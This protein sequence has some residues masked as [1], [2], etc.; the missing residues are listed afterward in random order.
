MALDDHVVEAPPDYNMAKSSA[1]PSSAPT[2]PTPMPMENFAPRPLPVCVVEQHDD[3]L[4][5]LHHC[6]RRKILPQGSKSHF[7]HF[8]AHPDLGASQK[9]PGNL[10]NEDVREVYS[11]LKGD[12]GGIASWV[13]P[14]VLT[15]ELGLVTWV[16]QA[17]ATQIADGRYDGWVGYR[18]RAEMDAEMVD[19]DFGPL[20]VHGKD[21]AGL[22]Y[23]YFDGS[24]T[25][26]ADKAD[27]TSEG[28]SCIQPPAAELESYFAG[29]GS[30]ADFH[31]QVV[32]TG[33][34]NETS[35]KMEDS[36]L[37]SSRWVKPGTSSLDGGSAPWILDIDLD[38]FTTHNPFLK[39]VRPQLVCVLNKAFDVLNPEF[40]EPWVAA[41]QDENWAE[42]VNVLERDGAVA[43]RKA[44][45]QENADKKRQDP[46]NVAQAQLQQHSVHLAALRQL[47]PT[48]RELSILAEAADMA[49]LPQFIP[50]T[51]EESKFFVHKIRPRIEEIR[52]FLQG[53]HSVPQRGSTRARPSLVTIARS[54]ADG[55]LPMR[56]ALEVETEVLKML[57]HVYGELEVVYGDEIL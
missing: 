54:C 34:S 13:L 25:A 49:S 17:W 10:Y 29:P 38:Y 23:F 39:G 37:F 36:G 50:G 52:Q 43:S 42:A 32:S 20:Q 31:L 47:N 2:R 9:I 16:K 18:R 7:L 46:K 4:K 6:I 14:A 35:G 26:D 1:S 30:Y 51:G 40:D 41:L 28:G 24:L 15:G 45:A 27:K 12:D 56:F 22:D 33:I 57:G 21:F 55:F 11:A 44:S 5:F 3:A 48:R 8:D 53:D 19:G